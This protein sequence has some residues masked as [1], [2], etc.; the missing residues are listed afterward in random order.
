MND[1][2]LRLLQFVAFGLDLLALNMLFVFVYFVLYRVDVMTN[3]DYSQFCIFLNSSWILIS[4]LGGLYTKPH[5]ITLETFAKRTLQIYFYWLAVIASFL[6]FVYQ[7]EIPRMYI[8]LI[9][10]CQLAML[11]VSRWVYLLTRNY[12][13]HIHYMMHRVI[14]VGYNEVAK[15]LISVFEDEAPQTEIV[16]FC[17]EKEKVNELTHY[18]VIGSIA[19]TINASR[20]YNID[21]IYSTIAPEQDASIYKLMRDADQA[22]I[23]FRVVPNLNYFI[24]KPYYLNYIQDIPILKIRPEPLSEPDN[25][26]KKRIFDVVFSVLVIIFILS[27]LVP[28]IG[29][30]IW[31]ESPG[32]IFFIQKRTGKNNK[33]F[34]CYKFRSMKLNKEADNRQA[35]KNDNR[36][37][38][39]GRFIRKTNIDEMP[40]FFNVFWGHM[41][42]VGPRPHPVTFFSMLNSEDDCAYLQEGY[43]VRHFVKPGVTGWAQVN[44]FRGEIQKSEQLKKRIQYD[45]WYSENWSLWLDLRIIFLTVYRMVKGD[46]EAF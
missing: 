27:W 28:L 31:L 30:L 3:N 11:F 23:H 37:T 18:P 8:S 44:G 14:I 24:N 21:E 17:E 12:L 22:C 45:I 16:G 33:I 7:F 36:V 25:R 42:V 46:K 39:I 5:I 4:W 32:P 19:N 29:L 9:L 6:F 34:Y 20:L 13:K 15:K 10:A 26:I 41:S 2:F 1:R 38:N 43:P 35:T 40:Q